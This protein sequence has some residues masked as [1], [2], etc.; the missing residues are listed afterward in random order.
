MADAV[1]V[2]G[3]CPVLESGLSEGDAP[4]LWHSVHMA[5]RS[6]VSGDALLEV[7]AYHFARLVY[8]P[9]PGGVSLLSDRGEGF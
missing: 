7:C 2:L 3:Q 8:L 9:D 4:R 1:A 5:V 6:P